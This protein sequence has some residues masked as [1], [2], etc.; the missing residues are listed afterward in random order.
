M[1]GFYTTT[2]LAE[3]FGGGASTWR[4]RAE[5]GE[6]KHAFK[7][8]N[9]WFIPL[10]DVSHVGRGYDE[11]F[12]DPQ[13]LSPEVPTDPSD[14]VLA[15]ND[16]ERYGIYINEHWYGA[17]QALSILSYLTK[18]REWLEQKAAE[19]ERQRHEEH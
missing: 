8:G 11:E 3:L 15:R 5:S 19:N 4:T 12:A 9:T 1:R 14:I 10:L 13:P 2:Q 17:G 18:H 16:D 7:Q 6:F